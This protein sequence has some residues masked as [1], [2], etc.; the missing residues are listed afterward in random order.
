MHSTSHCT[1]VGKALIGKKVPENRNSG[2]CTNVILSKSCQL[3]MY[4]V[5]AMQ[6]ALDANPMRMV[7]G[8]ARIAHHECTSPMAAMITRNAAAYADPRSWLHA[9]SPR[10]TSPVVSG[11]A[12]IWS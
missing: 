5:A 10:A 2:S 12:S 11:V 8:K 9:I 3:F 7:A 4:V 6:T 1:G